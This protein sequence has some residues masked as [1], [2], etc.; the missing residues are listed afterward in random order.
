MGSRHIP[1]EFRTRFATGAEVQKNMSGPRFV[2]DI[3]R[4]ADIRLERTL[5]SEK[6]SY[7]GLGT[8]LG[9]IPRANTSYDL[10]VEMQEGF[11]PESS[12]YEKQED[13]YLSWTR[14][15]YQRTCTDHEKRERLSL[16]WTK[17]WY[18]RTRI[19]VLVACE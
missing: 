19:Q 8:V 1:L 5:K 18:E 17:Y 2:V 9:T 10:S 11:F 7:L 13:K 14:Y 3:W 6:A 15:W 16:S 12:S 4:E